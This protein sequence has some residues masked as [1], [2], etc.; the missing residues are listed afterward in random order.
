M[1]LHRSKDILEQTGSD[2]VP[3]VATMNV[4][5]RPLKRKKAYVK[6]QIDLLTAD[7]EYNR[8]YNQKV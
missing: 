6:L 2:P 1:L 3:I 5:L 8:Q 4:K 7:N